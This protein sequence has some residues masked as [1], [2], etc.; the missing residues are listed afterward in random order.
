M[1]NFNKKLNM[2]VI[3]DNAS[4]AIR[5]T[6][7]L[8]MA[9]TISCSTVFFD[10]PQPTDSANL[11]SVPKKFR[12][13]WRN[14]T[15][16]YDESILI[17]KTSYTQVTLTKKSVPMV[18]A[19]T[20]DE[21]KIENGKIF[22][23]DDDLKTGYPYVIKNDTICFVHRKVDAS[24]VLSDSVLLRAAKDC[25]VL[26]IKKENWWEIVFIQKMKNGEIRISYPVPDSFMPM[27]DKF[28]ISVLDSTKKGVTFY[29]AGFKSKGITKVIPADGSGV[30]Y[31]LNPDSTF[32][33]PK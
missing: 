28:N 30:L 21:Y 10:Q 6:Y 19:E 16:Y 27:K 7:L 9:L 15:K 2:R 32:I 14:F 29:H 5:F 31:T 17:D 13:T 25:Y 3:Y 33:S 22:L 18:T 24:V 4:L 12:G 1:L 11:K 23:T 20:S 8:I 26:N